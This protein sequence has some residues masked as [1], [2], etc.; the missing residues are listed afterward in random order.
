[1]PLFMVDRVPFRVYVFAAFMVTVTK[2]CH[3][4]NL[5]RIERATLDHHFRTFRLWS[6]GLMD[7]GR[8]NI[9]VVETWRGAGQ[10]VTGIS[11]G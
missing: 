1:M 2:L 6:C 9:M 4:S 3:G 7:L 5:R 11:Q 8:E 10:R